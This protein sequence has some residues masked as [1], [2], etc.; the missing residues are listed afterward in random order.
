MIETIEKFFIKKPLSHLS[1][2]HPY[3][4]FRL[5]PLFS[6]TRHT[7]FSPIK[8]SSK[9]H[10]PDHIF[11]SPI[12]FKHIRPPDI[13]VLM[14]IVAVLLRPSRIAFAGIKDGLSIA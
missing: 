9:L 12:L 13:S 2:I 14:M 3:F 11:D 4:V 6:F 5:T 10:L 7:V 1:I 8:Y